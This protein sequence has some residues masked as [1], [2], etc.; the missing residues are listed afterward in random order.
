MRGVDNKR[1]KEK[2]REQDV[3]T[4][5]QQPLSNRR[6]K[7]IERE[8]KRKQYVCRD[9]QPGPRGMFS[10]TMLVVV[11]KVECT[12]T[13]HSRSGS[14][15]QVP[16]ITQDQ[17]PIVKSIKPDVPSRRTQIPSGGRCAG[18]KMAT[19]LASSA[20]TAC[21]ASKHISHVYRNGLQDH[22]A[23]FL[24]RCSLWWLRLSVQARRTQEPAAF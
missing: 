8:R 13:P 20:A 11:M 19:E 22:G 7:D 23:S 16:S 15:L 1:N 12:G 3:E 24:R 2:R 17:D 6:S 9:G 21:P 14:L 4:T 10:A 5:T 18:A